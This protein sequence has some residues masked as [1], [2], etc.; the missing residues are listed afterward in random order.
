MLSEALKYLT[1]P[2]ERHFRSMGYLSEL[3]A[4]E[5][6]YKRCRE[7]WEPHL[8]KTK[9]VIHEA[10]NQTNGHKRAIVLGAGILSDIPI[11][12]LSQKFDQVE[13]VDV[14]FLNTTKKYLKNFSNVSWRA[15]D[16]TGIAAPLQTWAKAGANPHA[17]PAPQNVDTISLEG[18]DL[19][20]SA[21]ILSQLPLIPSAFIEKTAPNI[22]DQ[23]MQNFANDIIETHINL[24]ED[25]HAH[26]C[27]ITEIE[28]Q[29]IDGDKI[30]DSDD[31]LFGYR[32]GLDGET[33][34]WDLA[35]KGE[36]SKD[37]AIRNRV[38]G[39]FW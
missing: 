30:L 3:I 26:G 19:V 14:C 10:I 11:D 8:E 20:I 5:A 6:R 15:L 38:V 32:P 33:W 21:N 9:A 18:A 39:T 24:I 36:V 1:T 7:S 27:L 16:V 17:L 2:C 25:C 31:P 34:H 35:P 22:G 28:R 37:Y 29:F 23:T 4:L 12:A 13:L